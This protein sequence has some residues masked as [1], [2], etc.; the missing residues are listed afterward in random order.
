MG[1][2]VDV[3]YVYKATPNQLL[4]K[5]SHISIYGFDYLQSG[6]WSPLC[7]IY[8]VSVD[9]K[10]NKK[11]KKQHHQ[12]LN[13]SHRLI[14]ELFKTTRLPSN[15]SL[16]SASSHKVLDRALALCDFLPLSFFLNEVDPQRPSL[17]IAYP[18]RGRKRASTTLGTPIS[19][20]QGVH[21]VLT[22]STVGQPGQGGLMD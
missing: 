2:V 22:S 15:S 4:E 12:L 11:K 17:S 13:G 1:I 19:F 7:P 3:Q 10:T 8:K 18:Y 20:S 5:F 6:I 16:P 9:S 21:E 14:I